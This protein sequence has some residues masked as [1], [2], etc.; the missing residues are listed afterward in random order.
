MTKKILF[1]FGASGALLL[2]ASSALAVT[3][4]PSSGTGMMQNQPVVVQFSQANAQEMQNYLQQLQQ[5]T[6]SAADQ[7]ALYQAM[8][9]Y[10]Y[11]MMGY[12]AASTTNPAGLRMVSGS[13]G[14]VGY[15]TAGPFGMM[16]YGT[17]G[18][19]WYGLMSILSVALI[20]VVLLLLIAL[21]WKHIKKHKN[22]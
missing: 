8:Q 6:L 7:K 17:A 21:L 12:F 9:G 3:Y 14:N 22:G 16:G 2:T 15:I 20:W 5:G 18:L 10:G 19:A 4:A 13:A 1:A 11:P